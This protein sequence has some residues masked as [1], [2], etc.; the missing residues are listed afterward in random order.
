MT[1]KNPGNDSLPE[2]WSVS[3]GLPEGASTAAHDLAQARFSLHEN[4]SS[5][6]KEEL[7]KKYS[8]WAIGSALLLGTL[9]AAINWINPP[10]TPL[11]Y[12]NLGTA[13]TVVFAITWSII[14]FHRKNKTIT[15]LQVEKR[16]HRDSEKSAIIRLSETDFNRILWSYHSDIADAIDDYRTSARS[17]R[18]IHNKFQTFIIT[19]S[20]LVT[21]VTT[22]SGQFDGLEWAAAVLSFFV[23]VATGITGYFKFRERGV[24]LQRAADDLEYEYNSVQLGIN[25]YKDGDVNNRLRL[26]AEKSESIKIEQRKRE[27]QMEQG[28]EKTSAPGSSGGSS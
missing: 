19:A 1:E 4:Q 22:A 24:N 10:K 26:F 20:L 2:E 14:N 21:G 23:A 15:S 8:W 6:N 7:G 16:K 17:Y 3:G 11:I 5:I 27:Q 28:P 12:I 13:A 25:S 18:S 9:I